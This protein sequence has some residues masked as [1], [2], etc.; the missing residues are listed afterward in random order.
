LIVKDL[1][2][3]L[4]SLLPPSVQPTSPIDLDCYA[5]NVEVIGSSEK[6]V[7]VSLYVPFVAFYGRI[8][9]YISHFLRDIPSNSSD[10]VCMVRLN[11]L[12]DRLRQYRFKHNSFILSEE[13]G[14][15]D[16]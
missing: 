1:P 14:F 15:I 8:V 3:F 10:S 2:T 7:S 11:I 4:R 13:V 16:G 5:L 6:S 12:A 9:S